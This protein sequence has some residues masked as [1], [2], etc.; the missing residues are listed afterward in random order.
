[1]NLN[2]IKC[3]GNHWC[4]LLNLNLDHPHFTNLEGVY[5]IWHSGQQPAVVYVGQGNIAQRIS[6]H[7]ENPEI[8]KFSHYGLFVTWAQVSVRDQSG[9]ESYLCQQLNPKVVAVYPAVQEIPVN[10]PREVQVNFPW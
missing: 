10:I 8:L 7:R 1:M 9:V 4:S 3:E 6:H 2:W 5:I